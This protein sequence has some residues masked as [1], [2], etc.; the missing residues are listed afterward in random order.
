MTCDFSH[1]V[2]QP[3]D[4]DQWLY[5]V[6]ISSLIYFITGDQ[7]ATL[8]LIENQV[9]ALAHGDLISKYTRCVHLCNAPSSVWKW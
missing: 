5:I 6:N 9:D 3:Y 7:A 8:H 4:L 1:F 2:I